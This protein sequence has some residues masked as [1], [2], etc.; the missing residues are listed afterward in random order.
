MQR[1]VKKLLKELREMY[2]KCSVT[3]YTRDRIGY[4]NLESTAFELWVFTD[5][6]IVPHSY[7][8]TL[9]EVHKKFLEKYHA[10]QTDSTT[11]RP[12]TP[13]SPDAAVDGDSGTCLP[14]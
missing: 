4:D 3:L 14:E 9:E 1:K 13:R 8:A 2:P 12:A 6:E 11:A 10:S 7:G 5:E